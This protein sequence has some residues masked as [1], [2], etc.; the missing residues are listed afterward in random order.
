VKSDGDSKISLVGFGDEP[1]PTGARNAALQAAN[2]TLSRERAQAVATYLESQ[3]SKIGLKGWSISIAAAA[4]GGSASM[5][6]A[7]GTVV[8][9][10][11]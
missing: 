6:G 2:I 10:L 7:N 5:Q 8:A 9:T 4:T 3:L 1:T 11:S